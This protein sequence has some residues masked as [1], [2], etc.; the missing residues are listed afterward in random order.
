VVHRVD[1][2]QFCSIMEPL[3]GVAFVG[4]VVEVLRFFRVGAVLLLYSEAMVGGRGATLGASWRGWHLEG[5]GAG[6]CW[7]GAES[8]AG[9]SGSCCWLGIRGR[10]LGKCAPFPRF[11]T[12]AEKF[13][14]E[15]ENHKIH[16]IVSTNRR[17][18]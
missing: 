2:A 18:N 12:C 1:T 6:E 3:A 15:D 9:K 13:D 17:E 10:F 14:P 4:V 8:L 5:S 11:Q 16:R 7:F